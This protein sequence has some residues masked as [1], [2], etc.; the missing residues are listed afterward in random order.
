VTR[1]ARFDPEVL[2]TAANLN[3]LNRNTSFAALQF[4][5]EALHGLVHNA[6]GGTM[7]TASSPAEPLFWL[8]HAFVDRLWARW[9]GEPAR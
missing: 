6:V 2:P 4:E 5:L 9:A 1:A 3:A 7:A 8:H